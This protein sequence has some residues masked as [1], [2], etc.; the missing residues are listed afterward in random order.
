MAIK[1][2]K[3]IIDNKGYRISTKDREIFEEGTLQ[4]FFGFSDSDMI[5]FIVYDA[6]ENQL[7]QGDDGKLV[8]YVPLSSENIKDYFLIADGTKLQ[9]FQFP[10]EYFID[11]ERLIKEAGYNNGI[12]KTEITLLNKRVGFDNINEKLWIQE[13]SPSR[14]EIRV[15]PI[16]NDVSNKTDLLARYNIMTEGSNFRDDIIPYVG[17]FVDMVNPMEVSGFI[18]KTYSEKWYNNFVAEFGISGFE[19]MVTKI[20]NDF[21]KSVYNE[22]SNRVSS[23]G[24]MNYG[25]KKPTKPSIRFSKEDVYKVSQRILIECVDKYLPK[26]AMQAQ[27][28]VDNVFDASMDKISEVINSRE[29]DVVIKANVPSIEVTETKDTTDT[30][31]IKEDAKNKLDILI[32]KEVPKEL[33]IPDFKIPNPIKSKSKNNFK[34]MFGL[35]ERMRPNFPKELFR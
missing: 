35:D 34:R 31:D 26:R 32:E 23:I 10:N 18:R 28:Q 3:E 1:T 4:S 24:D 27:T 9:A 7:P 30:D 5:E 14:N 11:A 8:R 25:K 20:Y 16:K 17:S 6:N 2:F 19:S 29:S 12:F 13:I 22:F 21:R 33:P 15:L